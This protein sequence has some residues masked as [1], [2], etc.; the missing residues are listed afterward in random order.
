MSASIV[1]RDPP[2]S[3]PAASRRQAPAPAANDITYTYDSE[4]G[5]Y[6]YPNGRVVPWA[7]VRSA[8]DRVVAA[9]EARVEDLTARMVAGEI[10]PLDWRRKM[11]RE[12]RA[13]Q[14]I[15]YMAARGGRDSM[16]AAD[17]RAMGRRIADQIDYLNAFVAEVIRSEA[18]SDAWVP[19]ASMYASAARG[20]YEAARRES[21]GPGDADEERRV[22]HSRDSC[23]ECVEY[24]ARGWV[25]VGTLPTPGNSCTCISNCKCTIEYRRIAYR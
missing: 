7:R 25:P 3:R 12:I 13:V 14:S 6:R 4:T 15:A 1:G 20:A 10:S 19:R 8:L 16:T 18:P 23:P 9:Y 22:R 5:R 24:A 21:L 2:A 11:A 17:R